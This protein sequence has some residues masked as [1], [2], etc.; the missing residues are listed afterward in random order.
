MKSK[1]LLEANPYLKDP[2]M[3]DKLVTES[4][5]TSF[6]VEGIKVDLKKAREVHIPQ[7]I[8]KAK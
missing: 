5:I 4:I 3:R 2:I 1:S 6:G 7:K 8:E